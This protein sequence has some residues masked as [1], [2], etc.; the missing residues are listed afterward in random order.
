MVLLDVG[1]ADVGPVGPGVALSALA[2]AVDLLG[3]VD[4]DALDARSEMGL[5]RDVEVLRRRLD[6]VTDQLAGHLDESQAFAV[7]GLAS[8]AVAVRHLGRLPR[9]EARARVHCARVLRDLPALAAAHAAGEVPTAHV[10]AVARV[11]RNPRVV[12]LLPVIEDV[13]VE[14]ARDHSHDG[15]CRW[16][17][18]WERLVDVDGTEH[19]AETSH[20]RRNGSVVE[21]YDGG[22]TLTGGFGNLQGAAVAETVEWFAR[23]E[24]LADWADARARLGDAATDADLPRT[25]AQRGADALAAI[26]ARARARAAVTSTAVPL[27]NIVVDLHTFETALTGGEPAEAPQVPRTTGPRVC[28]TVSGVP[29]APS[30]VVAAALAGQV[31]RVIIDSNS[32]VIDLGR[33]RRLFTGSAREAPELTN[34]LAHPDGLR[35][36]WNGCHR[37]RD[38]QIDHTIDASRGGPTDQANAAVLCD[39]HNRLKNHGWHPTRAPDGTWTIHRPDRTPTTPP[40]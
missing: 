28:R 37:R 14:M 2:R 1:E 17:R 34:T 30:D 36:I 12:D 15:F 6:A 18:E 24:L 4:L 11:A 20:A 33:R 9:G 29:L 40:A 39:T 22:F 26:F 35:C 25:A 27:V 32:N 38:L 3:A 23:A 16:L 8:A 13:I 21:N 10:R 19:D 31:R 7:D 5:V